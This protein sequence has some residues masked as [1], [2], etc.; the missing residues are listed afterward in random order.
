MFTFFS[1]SI[2]LVLI[3]VTAGLTGILAVN[4]VENYCSAKDY[5]ELKPEPLD[6]SIF[7]TWV[8]KTK[9]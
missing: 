8:Y 9:K 6:G 5:S 4:S 1:V 2:T 7:D 3:G